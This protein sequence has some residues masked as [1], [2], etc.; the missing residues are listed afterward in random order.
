MGINYYSKTRTS[1]PPQTT[2]E[3][4]P[5]S[6]SMSLAPAPPHGEPLGNFYKPIRYYR[7]TNSVVVSRDF[8]CDISFTY[9]IDPGVLYFSLYAALTRSFNRSLFVWIARTGYSREPTVINPCGSSR[10]VRH[11]L[12]GFRLHERTK[13]RPSTTTAQI[14]MMRWVE[15]PPARIPMISSLRM[16]STISFEKRF[17]NTT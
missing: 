2:T 5:V 9:W 14:P 12:R 1:P 15:S 10:K 4:D 7:R 3:V 13:T 11:Q 8:F 16:D 17:F 6:M